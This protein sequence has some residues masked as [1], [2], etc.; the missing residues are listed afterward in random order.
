MFMF[1]K[2]SKDGETALAWPETLV[3]GKHLC[4]R[5]AIPPPDEIKFKAC[6]EASDKNCDG[7]L[8]AAEFTSFFDLF[9]RFELASIQDAVR[10]SELRAAQKELQGFSI[11]NGSPS[12][13]PQDSDSPASLR[14]PVNKWMVQ[15]TA[16]QPP[17]QDGATGTV[18][19]GAFGGASLALFLLMLI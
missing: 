9:L 10:D 1:Q 13:L 4:S 11:T 18:A 16:Q 8:T 6:F 5:L 19:G 7:V 3:L 2:F 15:E 14:Q 12:P 17:V